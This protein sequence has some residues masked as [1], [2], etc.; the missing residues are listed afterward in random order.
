MKRRSVRFLICALIAMMT[1]GTALYQTA[2]AQDYVA[3]QVSISKDKVKID[4][5]VFYSHIVLEKQTLYSISIAYN[6]SIEDIYKYNPSVKENGLRKN[7]II[8]I[9]VV[10]PEVTYHQEVQVQVQ[11]QILSGNRKHTVKWYEDLST[12]AARYNVSEEAIV[13]ANGLK[14]RKVKN[15][16]VLII[17]DAEPQEEVAAYA[18]IPESDKEAAQSENYFE[19]EESTELDQY[20][21]SLLIID[22]WKHI[23]KHKVNATLILPFKATGTTGNRNNMD[24]YSGLLVAAK[25]FKENGTELKLNV[26]DMAGGISAIPVDVLRGSDIIIGPVSPNDIEQVAGLVGGQCP[27]VSPLDQRAEKLTSKYRNLIQAPASQYAQFA[28]I[29]KWIM[30][31]RTEGDKVIVISEKEAR[32][33]DAGRI[34]R[35]I[36]DRNGIG[37]TPFSYSILEGRDI[38]ASLEAVM[39]QTGTNRVVI[40]SESE[41]FVNDAV[42]NLNLIVHNKFNV[43]LYAPAKIRTFETI[44]VENF[45]NTSLHASLSYY[46]DYEDSKPVKDFILK[47]RAMFGAEPT[48]FAF[49]GYDLAKYFIRLIS[50]YPTNW[51]SYLTEAEGEKEE[52]QSYFDFQ[53]NGNGGYINNGVRRIRYCSD[54][55]IVE[56][57]YEN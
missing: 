10:E 43:E 36:I 51:M 30:Q 55:S 48:Q 26:Y 4:G 39:T 41:A 44:E 25:E 12:I 20:S 15:R 3:P 42:R 49:Q 28:D 56:G 45:H 9:P 5:K 1:A 7:D 57:F 52:L 11:E 21:D 33:N 13:K 18:A 50:E 40:A 8:N 53:Q 2:G 14:D 31:D 19:Q 32:Q 22:F 47:Y 23:T 16:Q 46:I 29:A 6:V 24:F 17:P 35:S 27:I 34:L 38:Q 37:Y 54:Y